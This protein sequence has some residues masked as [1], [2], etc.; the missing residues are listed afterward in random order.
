LF[1][2]VLKITTSLQDQCNI[3]ETVNQVKFLLSTSHAAP[4]SLCPWNQWYT[5]LQAKDSLAKRSD[6]G[7]GK[8]YDLNLQDLLREKIDF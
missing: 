5:L 3:F 4:K 2:K 8:S 1:S 7:E 6:C